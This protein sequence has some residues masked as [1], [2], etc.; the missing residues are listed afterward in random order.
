[1]VMAEDALKQCGNLRVKKDALDDYGPSLGGLFVPGGSKGKWLECNVCAEKGVYTRLIDL[2]YGVSMT[3]LQECVPVL[4]KAMRDKG[5]MT[6]FDCLYYLRNMLRDDAAADGKLIRYIY[7][8][9]SYFLIDEF[10]DT[11]FKE[12]NNFLPLF[13]NA[14]AQSLDTSVLIVGDVKQSIY[15]WRGS[16]WKLLD[17][18]VP[19]EFPKYE[20]EVLDTNY[21]SLAN[22]VEFNNAYFEAAAGVIDGINGD[23]VGLAAFHSSNGFAKGIAIRLRCQLIVFV[24]K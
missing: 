24:L 23:G 14:M 22:V 15:R 8:R 13:R 9:H 6:F 2:R 18:T 11:S 5:Y 3:F 4:E 12:W 16:D 19:D 1:M 17:S 21:R 20:E 7:D 10:Q